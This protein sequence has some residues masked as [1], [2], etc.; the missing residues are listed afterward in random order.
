M[1]LVIWRHVPIPSCVRRWKGAAGAPHPPAIATS[2][3]MPM[4]PRRRRRAVSVQGWYRCCGSC[5]S[6]ADP[7]V[8]RLIGDM[9]PEPRR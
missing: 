1:G 6:T 7:F 5:R 9:R 8:K 4:S 2:M 3:E